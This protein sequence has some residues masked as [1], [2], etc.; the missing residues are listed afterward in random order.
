MNIK[1]ALLAASCSLLTVGLQAQSLGTLYSM[2]FDYDV[3]GDGSDIKNQAGWDNHGLTGFNTTLY[4]YN[5]TG[6]LSYPGI[7]SSGGAISYSSSA[8]SSSGRQVGH[9]INGGAGISYEGYSAGQQFSFTALLN[10]GADDGLT[11]ARPAK[12]SFLS[13]AS[14]NDVVFGVDGSNMFAEVWA[15]DGNGGGNIEKF[16]GPSYSL[17]NTLAFHAIATKGTGTGAFEPQDS[18]IEL[19]FNPDFSDLG[20]PDFTITNARIGREGA[21]NGYDFLQLRTWQDADSVSLTWDE[22]SIVAI[23]EP[24]TYGAIFGLMGLGMLYLKRR[25]RNQQ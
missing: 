23:P 9:E 17:G 4:E 20:T 16:T 14:V 15:P 3:S 19:W 25:R 2:P 12:L 18:I 8:A 11:P 22:V 13:G 6:G 10:V 24:S 21:S 1:L 5:H 7:S